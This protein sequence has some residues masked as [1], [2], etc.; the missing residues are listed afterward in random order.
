LTEA[1]YELRAETTEKVLVLAVDGHID[2]GEGKQLLSAH[3]LESL[4]HREVAV[5]DIDALFDYR[6]RRPRVTLQGE[7]FESF[8]APRLSV[9]AVEDTNGR[10]FLLM[11]GAEPDFAWE[12]FAVAMRE[13]MAELSVSRLINLAAAPMPVPHTRPHTVTAHANR[14]ELVESY[15]VYWQDLQIP[16]SID[17][18]LEIRLG[19]AGIDA[20]GFAVHVPHYLAS[21]AYPDAAL[22]LL[23]HL[24]AVTGL[25][26]PTDDLRAA[27]EVANAQIATQVSSS[28]EIS[29]MVQSL[30]ENYDSYLEA[31]ATSPL[32]TAR[33]ALPDGDELGA[34]LERFLAEHD[35]S[36]SS[37]SS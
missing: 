10:T 1:G 21:S 5:F 35:E 17:A 11:T 4:P 27:A 20:M 33:G 6:G 19:E 37:G 8:Q 2:A 25:K 9:H 7:H 30:E 16:A 23:D 14:P 29:A 3:L 15:P 28:A 32:L 18:L 36:G 24:T 13:L 12:R 26:L 31:R 34:E 22:T